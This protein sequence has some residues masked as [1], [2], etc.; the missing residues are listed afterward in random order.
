V[1]CPTCSDCASEELDC[2]IL[3]NNGYV[4]VAED[5]NVTGQF[6]GEIEGAVM[7]SLRTGNAVFRKIPMFDYQG[8]CFDEIRRIT[9]DANFI[10][11]VSSVFELYNLNT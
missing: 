1:Q 9:S 8:L 2:F 11:T 5:R 10:F 7:N 6:F 4:V 3:D